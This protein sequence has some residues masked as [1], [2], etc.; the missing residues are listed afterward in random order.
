M[1]TVVALIAGIWFIFRPALP[2]ILHFDDLGNLSALPTIVDRESAW[3]WIQEGRAG[4]FG[5]PL[6]LATFALQHYEWPRPAAFLQWNI[7]LHIVNALLVF[8]LAVLVARR[9]GETAKRQILIGFA[10]AFA[11]AVLPFLNT[12]VLFI[13]QRMALLSSAFMLAGLVAYLKIRGAIDASWLRQLGALAAL[14]FFGLLGLF[15]KENGALIVVYALVLEL[16]LLTVARERRLTFSAVFLLLACVCLLAGLT[17]RAVWHACVE[18]TRGFDLSQRL[19]SQGILLA[20]Y[21][22]ALLLPLPTDLN[23]FRFEFLL[24]DTPALQWGMAIWGVLM[25]LPLLCWWGGR[26][27]VGWRWVGLVLAWFF[28]GHL[29]ESGWLNLEPYF[30]HRNYLPALGLMFA[31]VY[32]ISLV[33][34]AATL[35]RC[36][37]VAYIVFLAGTTWMNTSLWG[38]RSLA[39]E[40]WSMEQPRSV[41]AILNLA[42]DVERTQGGAQAQK[43]LDRFVADERDSVGLRLQ[44]LVSGCAIDPGTDHSAQLLEVKRAIATLPYEGWATD[45]VEKLMDAVRSKECKGVSTNEVAAI[46]AA[47]ISQPAYQCSRP[48]VHNMLWILGLVAMDHGDVQTAMDFYLKGLK[49]SPT[50]SMASFYLDL[51]SQQGDRAAIEELRTL[52]KNAPLPRGV[53]RL[54]WQDLR[55]R[56]ED[57]LS[58]YPTTDEIEN[59]RPSFSE[60]SNPR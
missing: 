6:A 8:W 24:R 34:K 45:L 48:A 21:L 43:L 4:P 39:S 15:S 25:L 13:V 47:F 10:V 50:Y 22:K 28:Y 11:W 5:R 33:R 20:G 3:R 30:A 44:G 19:G 2:G 41:R 36:I 23:P 49:E 35:W 59:P 46:A 18:L 14:A 55:K 38:N 51:A 29:M 7:A 32:G 17:P 42:Y 56:V 9:M 53:T 54:E 12:S 16:A 58:A 52:L 26:W 40:I 1:A 60:G 27:H 31:M 57:Q 37:L